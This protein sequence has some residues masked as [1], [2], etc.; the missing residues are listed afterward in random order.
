MSLISK[1]VVVTAASFSLCH[2]Y[3]ATPSLPRYGIFV[4]SDFCTSPMSRDMYGSR[5]SLRR[6]R[7]D[8]SLIYEYTDGSTHPLVAEALT[9]DG[10]AGTLHFKVRPSGSETAQLSG[11]IS[12][13]G[14][15]LVLRGVLFEEP[16][17]VYTLKRITNFSAP[18]P[19]CK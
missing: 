16:K 3:A 6:F 19:T 7:D 2:S 12:K 17:R 15:T 11:T 9:L 18:I 10:A 14:Q 4:Y 5:I 8:D 1:L 13:D